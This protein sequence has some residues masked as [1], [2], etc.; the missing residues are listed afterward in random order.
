[1][2]QLKPQNTFYDPNALYSERSQEVSTEMS[3]RSA[4]RAVG[5]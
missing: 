3:C 1:M 5:V 2:L 4:K